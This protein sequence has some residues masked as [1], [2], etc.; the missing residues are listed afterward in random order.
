MVKLIGKMALNND[1]GQNLRNIRAEIHFLMT[2]NLDH[3]TLIG[4][5]L[6]IIWKIIFFI[7]FFLKFLR[8][9]NDQK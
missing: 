5:L 8:G 6:L 2:N 9:N 1:I 7:K 4:R 3:L